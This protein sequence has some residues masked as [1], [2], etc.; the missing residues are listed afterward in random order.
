MTGFVKDIIY[1]KKVSNVDDLKKGIYCFVKKK[2][3][4]ISYQNGGCLNLSYQLFA[5]KSD[6]G[7]L[8]RKKKKDNN[9]DKIL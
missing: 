4:I 3:N 5:E 7:W 2:K 9:K 8:L 6:F 1:R